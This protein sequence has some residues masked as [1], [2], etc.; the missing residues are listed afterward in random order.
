M[1]SKVIHLHPDAPPKPEAGAACNGCGVCCAWAPC[2]LG[3]L[4][5]MKRHGRCRMLRWNDA[6]R[7]YGCGAL[8]GGRLRR[9][10]VGRWIAAGVGCDAELQ[11]TVES[12]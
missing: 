11:A 8:A 1:T 7:R 10:V 5:S 3:A 6:Q 2:P 12:S 9:A 4:L